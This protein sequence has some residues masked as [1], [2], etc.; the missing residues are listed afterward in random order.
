[1]RNLYSA[2]LSAIIIFGCFIPSHGQPNI[3]VRPMAHIQEGKFAAWILVPDVVSKDRAALLL[4]GTVIK[5]K[6][7]WF[8]VLGGVFKTPEHLYPVANLR[9]FN[10]PNKHLKLITD[11]EYLF[12]GGFYGWSAILTPIQ[13]KKAAFDVG[14]NFETFKSRGNS[15]GADFG[16]Y[17]SFKIPKTNLSLGTAYMFKHGQQNNA[18]RFYL[19]MNL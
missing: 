11:I 17:I 18:V 13:I 12:S 3:E 8:E 7:G 15:F 2:L 19:V 6:S 14:G 10:Q 5:T 16:P 4:A 9:A 1:M